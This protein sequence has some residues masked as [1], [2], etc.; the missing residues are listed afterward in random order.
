MQSTI[1]RRLVT[2]GLAALLAT[3]VA[4]NP[5]AAAQDQGGF[6]DQYL[7]ATTRGVSDMDVHPALK[8]TLFPVT[9]VLDTV[10]LPF[11]VIAGVVA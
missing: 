6:D 4:A 2:V 9:V 8:V 3:C 1:R 10:F 5:A 11:A 7:F